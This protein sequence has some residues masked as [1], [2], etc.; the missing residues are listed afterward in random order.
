V[1]LAA[2]EQFTWGGVRQLTEEETTLLARIQPV[3]RSDEA[4]KIV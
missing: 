4:K 2:G 1:P 3:R